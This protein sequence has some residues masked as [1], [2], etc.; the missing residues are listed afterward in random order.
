MSHWVSA[1]LVLRLRSST[2]VR[3]AL[4]TQLPTRLPKLRH[5]SPTWHIVC[6]FEDRNQSGELLEWNRL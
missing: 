1:H 3:T 4:A 5:C 6:R 2:L